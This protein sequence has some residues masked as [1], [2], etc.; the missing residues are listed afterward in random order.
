MKKTLFIGNSHTYV[1]NMPWVFTSVCKDAGLD[2]HASMLTFPGCDW[3]W[4]ISW[5]CALPNILYGGYD[6]VIL[7][8][9]AH[10]VDGTGEMLV[11]EAAE[12]AQAIEQ[13]GATTVF[14]QNW[15]KKTNPNEQVLFH[16]A[17]VRLHTSYPKTLI[18]PMGDVWYAL[19]E[20]IDLYADDNTHMNVKGAYLNACILAKTI[21]DINPAAL[22]STPMLNGRS[23]LIPP[24]EV[25]MIQKAASEF[26]KASA[27]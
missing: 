11:Q 7:Q 17:F 2:V 5:S 19:R 26:K 15:A 16:N 1:E 22:P 24:K 23:L 13:S 6:F 25:Q 14:S 27:E 20:Q 18:A 3:R 8:Q 21:F 9:R 12:L 4:H 10:P